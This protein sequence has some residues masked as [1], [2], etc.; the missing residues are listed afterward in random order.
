[1]N[2][3]VFIPS[4]KKPLKTFYCLRSAD[5]FRAEGRTR[6]IFDLRTGK[7]KTSG[8]IPRKLKD[9]ENELQEHSA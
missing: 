3:G 7:E 2:Y 5:V 1:M 4:K 8:T 6:C 9:L